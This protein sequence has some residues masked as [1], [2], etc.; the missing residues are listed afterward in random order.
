MAEDFPGQR[1]FQGRECFREDVR[2]E[3]GAAG[4]GLGPYSAL[5]DTSPWK[6]QQ[7]LK[8]PEPKLWTGAATEDRSRNQSK[9]LKPETDWT[10]DRPRHSGF[11]AARLQ[12][13]NGPVSR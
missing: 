9:N 13:E 6:I 11:S 8:G 1:T 4:T 10:G 5:E 12:G 3:R 2:S 7:K